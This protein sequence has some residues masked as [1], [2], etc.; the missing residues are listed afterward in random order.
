VRAQH[1]LGRCLATLGRKDEARRR[2][3]GALSIHERTQFD[4]ERKLL[5]ATLEQLGFLTAGP[6]GTGQFGTVKQRGHLS[7]SGDRRD[8]FGRAVRPRLVTKDL[9]LTR[10]PSL[11]SRGTCRAFDRCGGNRE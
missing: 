6:A 7:V 1:V 8:P 3:K 5:E 11:D 4:A 10:V 9:R 2:F